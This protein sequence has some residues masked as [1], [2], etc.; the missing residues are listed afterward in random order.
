MYL[1]AYSISGSGFIIQYKR[2]VPS[3]KISNKNQV[4]NDNEP[5]YIQIWEWEQ[6]MQ[7]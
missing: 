7:I 5:V 2:K 4:K 6:P 3:K 1:V